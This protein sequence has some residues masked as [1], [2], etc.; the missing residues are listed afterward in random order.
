MIYDI[1]SEEA[2]RGKDTVVWTSDPSEENIVINYDDLDE[3]IVINSYSQT[4]ECDIEYA[5]DLLKALHKAISLYKEHEQ[6]GT[7]TQSEQYLF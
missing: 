3:T 1:R 6:K 7:N 4:I 5:V 2:P